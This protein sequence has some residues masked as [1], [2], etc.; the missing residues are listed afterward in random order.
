VA[1]AEL[2]GAREIRAPDIDFSGLEYVFDTDILGAD[3]SVSVQK[4]R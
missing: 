3:Y 1:G 2:V 4:A